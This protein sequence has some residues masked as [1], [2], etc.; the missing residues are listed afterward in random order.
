MPMQRPKTKIICTL[1]PSTS[2]E[3]TITDMVEAGMSV[4]RL[5]LSHGRLD[6]HRES[7]TII[8]RVSEHLG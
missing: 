8:N 7:I 4:A 1:G 6:Q 3:E 5:N 2:T